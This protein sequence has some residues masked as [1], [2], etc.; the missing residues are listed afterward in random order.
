MVQIIKGGPSRSQLLSELLAPALG[1]SL[2]SLGTSYFANKALDKTLSD[3]SFDEKPYEE[4]AGAL[5]R[6]LAPYGKAGERLFERRMQVETASE[7]K[8]QQAMQAKQAQEADLLKYERALELQRLKGEQALERTKAKPSK[9]NPLDE[10]IPQEQLEKIDEVITKNP[11]DSPD[12]IGIKLG[13]AGVNPRYHGTYVQNRRD[14]LKAYQTGAEFSKGREKAV[15]DYVNNAINEGEEASNLDYTIDSAEKAIRG[16]VAGPGLE[17]LAKHNPYLQLLIGLT[18]DES[19]L[20][21]ENKKLLAGTK[22]IFGSKPTEREI[23]LLL[24][25]MLPSIG[26]SLEANMAGLETIRK[27]NNIK[28]LRSKM[29]YDLTEGGIK[30]IPGIEKKVSDLMVPFAEKFRDELKVAN[31][32]YGEAPKK[33]VAQQNGQTIKVKAPD[34]SKWNMTQEQIDSARRQGVIF[35]PIK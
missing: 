30:Y 17:A 7:Q 12:E 14:A 29:V 35:E 13:K 24:N 6:A 33:E 8:K 19:T 22:S 1:E 5:E 18:P 21:A 34:G 32:K 3:K 9:T 27:Y 28:K 31:E 23:F 15:L 26:K 16:E 10:P 25:S 4:K 11:N 2:A 20:L